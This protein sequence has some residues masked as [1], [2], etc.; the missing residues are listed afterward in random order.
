MTA[1]TK[2]DSFY[3]PPPLTDTRTNKS[4]LKDSILSDR[5]GGLDDTSIG[6]GQTLVTAFGLDRSALA[7]PASS[8]RNGVRA[9]GGGIGNLAHSIPGTSAKQNVDRGRKDRT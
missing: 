2:P 6:K 7:N 1:P 3:S 8:E 5:N 4:T 9:L